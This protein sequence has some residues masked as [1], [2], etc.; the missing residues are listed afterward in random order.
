M[1]RFKRVQLLLIIV[2]IATGCS[3]GEY[4]PNYVGSYM[5][6]NEHDKSIY[7][8]CS[9]DVILYE[10]DAKYKQPELWRRS[11]KWYKFESDTLLP[12]G[13]NLA[14]YDSKNNTLVVLFWKIGETWIFDGTKWT[15]SEYKFLQII[16]NSESACSMIYNSKKEIIELYCFHNKILY[17]FDGAA[18]TIDENAIFPDCEFDSAK[19]F[20]SDDDSTLIANGRI[21]LRSN[22]RT[23]NLLLEYKDK[24]WTL[25]EISL[26]DYIKYLSYDVT[27]SKIILFRNLKSNRIVEYEN[28]SLKK[29]NSI[30]H[31]GKRMYDNYVY[32]HHNSMFIVYG[33]WTT[34]GK[35]FYDTWSVK[36]SKEK[37]AYIW[38][39]LN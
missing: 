12:E 20:Y 8:F 35:H 3:V 32:D 1:I 38:T 34:S 28:G 37:D 36:Y 31:P 33:G 27:A 15:L 24:K 16:D 26:I 10:G 2:I 30:N 9:G 23:K 39:E 17:E 19:L 5:Y 7:L 11:D 22:D 6:Y 4:P 29:L 25:N 13:P 21:N 18:W 14:C